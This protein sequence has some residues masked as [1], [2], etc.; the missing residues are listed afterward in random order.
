MLA[1]LKSTE[2]WSWAACGKHP[3]AKDFFSIGQVQP[4]VKALSEW[5]E[6]GYDI[7]SS[8]NDPLTTSCAWRF[9]AKGPK[10]HALVCGI[11][12]DS[13][14]LIGR[15]Y[16]L[17]IMGEG[18]LED[19]EDH[20][21]L[22]ALACE[23]AWTQMEYIT[24][25]RQ[26]SFENFKNDL[27]LCKAPESQWAELGKLGDTPGESDPNHPRIETGISRLSKENEIFIRLESKTAEGQMS[28]INLWHAR[29]KSD[30]GTIPN[31]VFMGGNLG[32]NCLALFKRALGSNDFVRLWS[33]CSQGVGI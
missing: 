17:L 2:E 4:L 15:S 10:R 23:R 33:V 9:W 18:L 3:A 7:L 32:H 21:E 14:D 5:V 11:V 22:L 20:W 13:C 31:S 27:R 16:P 26:K 6:K 29:L 24:A 30:L 28:L 12:K 1:R 8:K 19:W 25:K